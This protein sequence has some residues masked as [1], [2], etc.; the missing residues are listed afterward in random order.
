MN[1]SHHFIKS[2]NLKLKTQNE[3]KV[4]NYIQWNLKETLK[5]FMHF[6]IDLNIASEIAIFFVQIFNA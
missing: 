1:T 3:N 4:F 5:V 6:Y 2:C